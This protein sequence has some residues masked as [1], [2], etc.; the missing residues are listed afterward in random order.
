MRQLDHLC[1][2]GLLGVAP[3]L[4]FGFFPRLLGLSLRLLGLSLFFLQP[5]LLFLDLKILDF[6][7]LD[8]LCP[9]LFGF[10]DLGF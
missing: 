6:R 2:L 4:F 1:A 8:I 7:F 3:L 9:F 10:L 5:Y